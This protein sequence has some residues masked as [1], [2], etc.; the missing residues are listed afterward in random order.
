MEVELITV[1]DVVESGYTTWWFA[2]VGLIFFVVCN[3]TFLLPELAKKFNVDLSQS[4]WNPANHLVILTI[5]LVFSFFWT[6]ISFFITYAEYAH[7]RDVVLEDSCEMVE[8]KVENF[9]PMPWDGHQN[10]TFR[11]QDVEFAYSDFDATN[12]FNNT[13]SHGG[14]IKAGLHVRICYT[15]TDTVN[16]ILRLEIAK[17]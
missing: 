9:N 5:A 15:P 1:F 6:L 13:K 12:A 17:K 7:F 3:L 10:E 8:G 4:P 16:R 2:S 11:V 14:P